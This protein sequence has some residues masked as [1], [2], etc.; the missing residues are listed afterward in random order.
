MTD[1]LLP[2]QVIHEGTETAMLQ[3]DMPSVLGFIYLKKKKKEL[4]GQVAGTEYE[5]RSLPTEVR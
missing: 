2:T 5:T 1:A 3:Q 4:T